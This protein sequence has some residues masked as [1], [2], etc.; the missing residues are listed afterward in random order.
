MTDRQIYADFLVNIN[1][2]FGQ[3][4]NLQVNLGTSISDMYYDALKNR[5]PIAD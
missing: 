3:D 1:K 5:G 2:R 4:W